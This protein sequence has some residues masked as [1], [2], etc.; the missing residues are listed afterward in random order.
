MNKTYHFPLS[1]AYLCDC[2][3]VG[4]NAMQCACGDTRGML[5]LANVL[6][7]SDDPI[8]TPERVARA[9]NA[10]EEAMY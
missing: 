8:V 10:M 3:L 2:G 4:N 9:L 1:S 7:R 5:C 6:N